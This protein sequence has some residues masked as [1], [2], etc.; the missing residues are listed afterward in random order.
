MRHACISLA[1]PPCV[2][3]ICKCH[4]LLPFPCIPPEIQG[5]LTTCMVDFGLMHTKLL[6]RLSYVLVHLTAI[7]MFSYKQLLE[8]TRKACRWCYNWISAYYCSALG[9]G[10]FIACVCVRGWTAGLKYLCMVGQWYS[11]LSLCHWLYSI[12][13]PPMIGGRDLVQVGCECQPE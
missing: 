4:R 11:M 8:L 1:M 7:V 5:S 12:Q 13:N 2:R 10:G 9:I 3:F 6:Y